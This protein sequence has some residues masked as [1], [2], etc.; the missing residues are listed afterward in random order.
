M[1]L[2]RLLVALLSV[3]VTIDARA[4][5]AAA[6]GPFFMFTTWQYATADE[7]GEVGAVLRRHTRSNDYLGVNVE[8]QF[9]NL[10]GRIS[11]THLYT[12]PPSLAA[13]E[14]AT[15]GKCGVRAGLIIY[16]GEHWQGTPP[17]E[18]ADMAKAISRG[19]AIVHQTG[20]QDYGIAPDGHYIGIFP[21]TCRYDPA[22]SIH[23]AIDWAGITLFDIQAQRLLGP[24]C[25]ERAG[26]DAYVAMVTAIA[27]DVRARPSFPKIVAQL[28]FR[29]TSPDKM[30]AAIKQLSGIVDGFYIAYPRNVGPACSY[31]SSANLDQVLEAIHQ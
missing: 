6:Q 7:T 24:N 23:H 16:D 27:S 11:R 4:A 26:V 2:R 21:G 30:I 29:L 31:C 1:I 22:A 10:A 14:R 15:V 17:D 25:F 20:C 8:L 19:K 5:T 28:S 12:L 9:P 3:V 18:Q 13:V